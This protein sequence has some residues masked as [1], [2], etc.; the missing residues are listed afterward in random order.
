MLAVLAVIVLRIKHPEWERPYRT[1]GYPVT[2]IAYLVF[3]SCFLY[4]VYTG[5]PTEANIGLVLIAIGIPA[6]YGYR[7]WAKQNPETLHDGQ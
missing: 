7:W 6:Y 1:L 5:Q 2:P 3:Y 4:Y